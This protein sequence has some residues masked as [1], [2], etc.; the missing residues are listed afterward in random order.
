MIGGRVRTE[1]V[2]DLKLANDNENVDPAG[3]LEACYPGQGTFHMMLLQ[4][5]ILE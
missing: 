2:E 4:V 5:L 1:S 3:N